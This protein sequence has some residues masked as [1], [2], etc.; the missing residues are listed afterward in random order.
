MSAAVS[1]GGHAA[2]SGQ[3]ILTLVVPTMMDLSVQGRRTTKK[4]FRNG[5]EL[6]TILHHIFNHL[7]F[8]FTSFVM[9]LIQVLLLLLSR[10]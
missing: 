8:I 7:V 3:T 1:Q 2:R 4:S 10:H 5:T 9:L 6:L